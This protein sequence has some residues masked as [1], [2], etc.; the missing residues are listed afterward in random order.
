VRSAKYEVLHNGDLIEMEVR[1]CMRVYI[2]QDIIRKI[3]CQ[4]KNCF[5]TQYVE[6]GE[7][8]GKCRYLASIWTIRLFVRC[9][10]ICKDLRLETLA[11]YSRYPRFRIIKKQSHC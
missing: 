4:K 1:F 11:I 2:I 10:D 8:G 9:C 5:E 6:I 7:W 3:A